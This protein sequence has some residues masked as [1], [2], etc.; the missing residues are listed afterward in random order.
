MK[1]IIACSAFFYSFLLTGSQVQVGTFSYAKSN[2]EQHARYDIKQLDNS[3]GI[4][5]FDGC[6]GPLVASLCKEEFFDNTA[7]FLTEEN[8]DIAESLPKG[9]RICN[10]DA[11]DSENND[12]PINNQSSML[13]A[14]WVNLKTR[15]SNFILA[16]DSFACFIGKKSIQMIP[17]QQSILSN[18]APLYIGDKNNKKQR[19]PK[20]NFYYFFS[21]D[22][23]YPIKKKYAYLVLAT[24][25]LFE[26]LNGK[27]EKTRN[28]D[29]KKI[30]FDAISKTENEFNIQYPLTDAITIKSNEGHDPVDFNSELNHGLQDVTQCLLMR[31]IAKR[32]V[33]IAL[34]RGSKKNITVAVQ[35]LQ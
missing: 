15:H 35:S 22:H 2:E 10:Y 30:F 5:I 27:D 8:Y 21:Q 1:N 34:S 23:S 18:Q 20:E 4:G 9:L 12:D 7:Y 3:I 28:T 24:Y 32:L 17:P 13:I 25:G 33:H 6:N 14:S 26:I 11:M 31:T 19:L 29:F 16:G